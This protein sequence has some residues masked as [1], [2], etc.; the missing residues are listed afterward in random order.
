MVCVYH[1]DGEDPISIFID[2]I[3]NAMSSRDCVV[4]QHHR[5][6]KQLLKPGYHV[7]SFACSQ[8]ARSLASHQRMSFK[9]SEEDLIED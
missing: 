9:L 3:A 7:E 2:R 8:S 5:V 4:C 1:N 6:Q